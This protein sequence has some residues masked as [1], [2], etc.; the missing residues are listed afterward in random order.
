MALLT[1]I[2]VSAANTYF[3]SHTPGPHRCRQAVVHSF[4]VGFAWGAGFLV[5]AGIAVL[6]LVSGAKPAQVPTSDAAPIHL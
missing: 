3:A 2:S 5:V 1:S 6:A 4:R